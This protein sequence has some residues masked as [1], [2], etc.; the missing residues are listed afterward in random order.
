MK[1][2][3]SDTVLRR[4]LAAMDDEIA[5]KAG[6]VEDLE[7]ELETLHSKRKAFAKRNCPHTKTTSS[8]GSMGRWPETTCDLCGIEL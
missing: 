2:R 7:L 3:L 1:Q 5:I 8:S 4:K 6:E